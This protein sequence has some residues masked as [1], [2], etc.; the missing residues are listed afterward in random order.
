MEKYDKEYFQRFESVNSQRFQQAESILARD[1]FE[2]Y[3]NKSQKPKV[4]DIGCAV[5]YLLNNFDDFGFETFG[6]DISP[7][8]TKQAKLS[9]QASTF[10]LDIQ[11]GA[12]FSDD[13]FDL[14]TMFDVIEHLE[15]PLDA[16]REI[17]RIL[18]PHGLFILTTSNANSIPRFIMGKNW[19]GVSSLGHVLLY[20]RFTLSF[21]LQVAKFQILEIKTPQTFP[22]FSHLSLPRS[23][24]R[25]VLHIPW[26][27]IY[28]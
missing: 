1:A 26:G 2:R 22:F 15:K 10:C 6:I 17:H 11:A 27:A 24:L 8:A 5:G 12:P 23:L 19:A 9:T 7:H 13:F 20:T 28:G 14:I 16:L 21:T 18:K 4:L 25:A 3:G